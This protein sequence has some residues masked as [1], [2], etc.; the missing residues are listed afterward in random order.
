[1]ADD[2]E[3]LFVILQVLLQPHARLQVEMVGGLHNNMGE[4]Q[5]RKSGNAFNGLRIY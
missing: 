2:D 4:G 5:F 3:A 1:M